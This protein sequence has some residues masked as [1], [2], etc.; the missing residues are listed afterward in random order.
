MRW[1]TA[2][3]VLCSLTQSNFDLGHKDKEQHPKEAFKQKTE[4]PKKNNTHMVMPW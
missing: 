4:Q 1:L 3:T 2:A